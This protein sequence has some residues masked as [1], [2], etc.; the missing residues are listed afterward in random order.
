MSNSVAGVHLPVF[1]ETAKGMRMPVMHETRLVCLCVALLFLFAIVSNAQI[2]PG[3]LARAHQ[4]LSGDSNCTKCHEVSTSSPSFRCLQCHKEIAAEL[5]D[6]RGLHATF[7]R[8]GPPGSACVKCHSD[9][10]GVDFQIVRWNPTPSG[11]DHSKT[12]FVLDGKHVGVSCRACH[13]ARNFSPE[14]RAL[15]AE[16]DLNRTWLGLSAGCASC[17]KDPHQGRFGA[18]CVQ[19]HST[20]DW[21]GARIERQNFDHSR[22][23]FPLTGTHRRTLCQSCHTP[24]ANGQ[25]R[26]S[27]LKF[28]HCSDCH[29]D[30]HKGEFKQGCDSC[31][32]TT[33]WAESRFTSTFDHSKTGFP[34]LGKHAQ[35][36]CVKCHNGEDFT[37]PI[38]HNACADCHKPDPHGGQFAS[39]PDGGRCE[40]CHTVNGWSPSTFTAA[41]HAKTDFPLAFP[42]EN[43]KCTQCH[44]PA[45]DATRFK[46]KF[47]ACTDCH[48]DEHAGQ[49]AAAP[50]HNDCAQCH[51]GATFETT[52]YTLA[53]HQ[54]SSYPLVGSHQAV[55]CNQCHKPAPGSKIALYHF[56]HLSCTTC[57]E[58]VHHGQFETRMAALDRAGNPLGC[59]VCH[60][61][62]AWT[63]LS[64]FNHDQTAF[65]LRGLHRAVACIDC[66][67]PPNMETTMVNVRFD[68][69]PK[70]CSD[71]HEDPH[72]G[73]F[74]A[75]GNDCAS[76]HNTNKWIPSTFDHNKTAF[77]LRGAHQGVACSACHTLR[78]PMNGVLVLFYKP[79][80]TAC[81]SCHGSEFQ[82]NDPDAGR[83][84]IHP[85]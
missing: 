16:K 83:A 73:Q 36:D 58:D 25:P 67:K 50:W 18:N 63:E 60:S 24:D 32:N 17:H 9:H 64:K 56:R 31:H 76:C 12:G 44:I 21:K 45:G 70:Q 28:A 59:A 34:L 77:S 66:H 10:N 46:M 38:A 13:T 81:S 6:N 40:S 54:K 15:L 65:P 47:A 33:A 53:M 7:P 5:R 8:E 72:A 23:L 19:C 11:F 74:G 71:C 20:T 41:D 55:L 61:T 62:D 14:A 4:S 39:R 52:S 42:H 27:G 29:A 37:T 78:R 22:T 3:P 43:V 68:S 69:A 82:Q 1:G 48:N 75:R 79:T 51:N 80:P 2:S 49:F 26:W 30:P 85:K 84:S 35:V 57:H